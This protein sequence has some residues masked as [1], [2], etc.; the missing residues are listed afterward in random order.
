MPFSIE[1]M[2]TVTE[3]P[4]IKWINIVG[5]EKAGKTKTLMELAKHI[6][7]LY[8][9]FDIVAGTKPY[10]GSVLRVGEP[11]YLPG[12]KVVSV[13][14]FITKVIPEMHK[15]NK[16]ILI[17]DPVNE[18]VDMVKDQLMGQFGVDDLKNYKMAGVGN[19]W[20][21]LY[22]KI[23]NYFA[24]FFAAFPLIITVSHLKLDKYFS[25]DTAAIQGAQ[26]D[27]PGKTQ[28][29]VQRNADAHFVFTSKKD[30]HGKWMSMIN[31]ENS[32]S[33][34]QVPLG[35]RDFEFVHRVNTGDD[36]IIEIGKMFGKD[37]TLT[38]PSR[39]EIKL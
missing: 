39:Q 20:N 18:F 37:I 36:L 30:E 14:D 9:D 23:Q 11:S 29:Y 34:I 28:Q 10:P 32:A 1:E 4:Q 25:G 17:L 15:L 2:L 7:C 5:Y 33:M 16:K 3:N 6:D 8:V 21:I 22:A 31:E 24:Q 38:Q 27:F 35:C 19:G 12:E 13:V 26:L